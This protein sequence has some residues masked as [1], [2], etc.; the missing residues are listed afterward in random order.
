MTQLGFG[1][2]PTRCTGCD[3]CRVACEQSHGLPPASDWRRVEKLLPH[4]GQSDLRF[5]SWACMHCT[6]PACLSACPARA[7][8]KR[9]GDGI[10]LHL[11][12]RCIGCRYC[13][14]ACPYGAPRY[15]PDAGIVTK[16]DF[17]VD[18]LA[19]GLEPA[20]VETCFSQALIFGPLEE[21]EARGFTTTW[22]IGLP[23]TGLTNP[24]FRICPG[25]R[26]TG[27]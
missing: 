16:C 7:Y 18:R 5:L 23:E 2:D 21:L 4:A 11:D 8:I 26:N 27:K 20:C 10:V 22:T 6:E 3:A 12:K 1:F 15:N 25:R 19:E 9:E 13:T 24:S 14:W 17:C